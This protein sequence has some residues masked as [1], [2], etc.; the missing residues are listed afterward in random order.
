MRA[1]HMAWFLFCDVNWHKATQIAASDMDHA[2]ATHTPC[3]INNSNVN[4]DNVNG[5]CH[6]PICDNSNLNG[7]I[8]NVDDGCAMCVST[9]LQCTALGWAA[10]PG[11]IDSPDAAIGHRG[12][13][14]S[15]TENRLTQN[16]ILAVFQVHSS[17]HMVAVM[18][19]IDTAVHARRGTSENKVGFY[20]DNGATL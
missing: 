1:A 15:A 12:G 6:A 2:G 7:N 10:P 18:Y 19:Q 3:R 8:D 11:G 9:C 13:K 4:I 17:T 16:P 5:H 14:S 20:I